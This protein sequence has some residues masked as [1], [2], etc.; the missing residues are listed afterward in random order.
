MKTKDIKIEL[1]HVYQDQAL[2]LSEVYYWKRMFVLG[3][4]DRNN[5]PSPGRTPDEGIDSSIHLV[6]EKNL[7]TTAYQ[8]ALKLGIAV[9]TFTSHLTENLSFNWLHLL[10]STL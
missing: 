5:L 2:S 6:L 8:I 4:T 9:S 3:R 1:D 10:V 7:R